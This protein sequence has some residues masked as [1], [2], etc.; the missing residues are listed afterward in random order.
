MKSRIVKFIIL[1]SLT[2][3]LF[4]S[5]SSP[6]AS[7]E[8][9][10]DIPASTSP[11]QEKPTNTVLPTASPPASENFTPGADDISIEA[12]K[13]TLIIASGYGR[14][15]KNGAKDWTAVVS[16]EW[17]ENGDQ[18]Q[19]TEDGNALIWLKD[20][21]L[22]RFSGLTDFRLVEA[23]RDVVSGKVTVSGHLITGM[24]EAQVVPLRTAD[25]TFHI[26]FA[27]HLISAEYSETTATDYQKGDVDVEE[28]STYFACE[29]GEDEDE[30][31]D[32]IIQI[33][34]TSKVYDVQ[35]IGDNF[36]AIE[37]PSVPDMASELTLE[38]LEDDYAE[39]EIQSYMP[40]I[41]KMIHLATGSQTESQNVS[42]E[43]SLSTTGKLNSGENV[44]GFSQPEVSKPAVIPTSLKSRVKPL[45]YQ[46]SRPKLTYLGSFIRI[47]RSKCYPENGYGCKYPAGCDQK[48]GTGCT[49]ATG[50]NPVTKAGCK[51]ATLHCFV[52]GEFG[53]IHGTCSPTYP[54]NA[55]LCK[56]NKEGDCDKF[57]DPA[58]FEKFN[59]EE[60]C[61]VC[62][63]PNT[64]NLPNY[65]YFHMDVCT[66][67]GARPAG[68]CSRT[69]CK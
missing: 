47:S 43:I 42:A 49:L 14:I 2:V 19:L 26:Y 35:K 44:Y 21:S 54:K 58:L 24:L 45:R 11:P 7:P 31:E 55:L 53:G 3:F 68:T 46:M 12:N 23:N 36:F 9:A 10:T 8:A 4:A 30:D 6:T 38:I 20:G 62:H 39:G 59:E 41:G 5:C 50:C 25:S 51:K 18:I 63:P 61:C 34:G 67:P 29:M 1:L 48:T 65:I 33:Q 27:N 32:T 69:T 13:N 17:L 28:I 37:Y 56:S 60:N 16:G 64:Q 15:L 22:I 52:K 57:Y 66:E 40:S